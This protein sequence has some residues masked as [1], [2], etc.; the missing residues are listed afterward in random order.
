MTYDTQ[1][2]AQHVGL[3]A[4]LKLLDVLEGTHFDVGMWCCGLTNDAWVVKFSE[5][6][7]F[8]VVW[9][10]CAQ[11]KTFC[12]RRTR[13]LEA[14]LDISILTTTAPSSEMMKFGNVASDF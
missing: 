6:A 7:Q 9:V 10:V 12:L 13:R 2:E 1:K 5:C 4:L 3:L 8:R 14:F 11:L